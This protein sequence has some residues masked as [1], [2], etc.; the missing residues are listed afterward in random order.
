MHMAGNYAYG[1]ATTTTSGGETHVISKPRAT[2]TIVCF[3]EKP[4]INGLVFDAEYVSRPIKEKYG[5]EDRTEQIN[6]AD[7]AQAPSS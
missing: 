3:K 1:T 2:N 4:Q 5:L 6:P 7:S